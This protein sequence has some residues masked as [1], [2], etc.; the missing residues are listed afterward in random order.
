MLQRAYETTQS[1]EPGAAGA[2]KVAVGDRLRGARRTMGLSLQQVASRIG[3]S[4]ATLSRVENGKQAIDLD[5][6]LQLTRMLECDP[7]EVLQEGTELLSP[8]GENLRDCMLRLGPSKRAKLWRELAAMVREGRD[9]PSRR[10]RRTETLTLEI[11]E[12]L[13]QMDLLAAEISSIRD[14]LRGEE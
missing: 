10:V 4:I 7:R 14:R 13:A 5:L 11:E 6:F 1:D 9:E 8:E 12:L 3:I 2:R